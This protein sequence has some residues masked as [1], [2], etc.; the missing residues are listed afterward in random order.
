MGKRFV[1]NLAAVW[2]IV[3]AL[4]GCSAQKAEPKPSTQPGTTEVSS[5]GKTVKLGYVQWEDAIATT[6]V[7]K[8]ALEQRLGV[9]VEAIAVDAGVMWTGIAQ[10]DFDAITGA[11]LPATHAAY[12]AKF[13]DQVLDA[14]INF[15]GGKNGLVVPDYVTIDS[16]DQIKDNK[17]KFKGR[18]IG[19][20]AGAGLMKLT[21]KTI[22]DY[23]LGVDLVEGSDAA[24]VAALKAA[25]EKKE[26]IVVTGWSPHWM[27]S[28]YKL[29]FLKDPKGTMGG[30]ETVH[31]LAR[32]GLDKEMPDVYRFLQKFHW[33]GG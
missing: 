26:W 9:K 24:M 1:L 19:I 25:I 12:W 7:A 10:G 6:H 15:E 31:S 17:D 5:K 18:I 4:T 11:W 21:A 2:V 28:T 23:G 33:G 13:K 20:D 22:Q 30:E 8:A 14:G 27:F 3:F 32:K 16:I 29:K